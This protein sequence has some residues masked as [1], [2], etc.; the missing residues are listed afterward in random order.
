MLSRRLSAF[1]VDALPLPYVSRWMLGRHWSLPCFAVSVASI[2]VDAL[3]LR[4]CPLGVCFAAVII[5]LPFDG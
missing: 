1:V 5:G 2:L 3:P 4:P